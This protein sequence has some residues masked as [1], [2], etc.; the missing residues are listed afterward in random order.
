[1]EPERGYV[2]TTHK[3]TDWVVVRKIKRVGE[4]SP[5]ITKNVRTASCKIP[6]I[7]IT[8]QFSRQIFDK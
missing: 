5:H 8:F 2:P 7:L 6:V 1:M 3:F 4:L